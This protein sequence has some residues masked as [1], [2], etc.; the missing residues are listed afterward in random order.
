MGEI[1]G[2]RSW[3]T[4]TLRALNDMAS[5]WKSKPPRHPVLRSASSLRLCS[6]F[7]FMAVNPGPWSLQ[8]NYMEFFFSG[9]AC[10]PCT[11][12]NIL[13]EKIRKSNP[14]SYLNKELGPKNNPGGNVHTRDAWRIALTGKDIGGLVC[15]Q[16]RLERSQDDTEIPIISVLFVLCTTCGIKQC[17]PYALSVVALNLRPS[18]IHECFKARLRGTGNVHC[19]THHHLFRII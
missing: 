19:T 6:M 3:K 16:P 7:T 5:V 17:L 18:W 12:L 10:L 8:Q 4:L 11:S 13:L 14:I 1:I 9:V 15:Q 2:L